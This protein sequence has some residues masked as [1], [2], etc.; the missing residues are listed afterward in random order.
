MKYY[1]LEIHE[2]FP[3]EIFI[4]DREEYYGIVDDEFY[5]LVYDE[6]YTDPSIIL[7]QGGSIEI[8]GEGYELSGEISLNDLTYTPTITTTCH[9][10]KESPNLVFDKFKNAFS[11]DERFNHIKYHKVSLVPD[12]NLYRLVVPSL[13][14]NQVF[15][16]TNMKIEG[17]NPISDSLYKG[18]GF[19]DYQI[20]VENSGFVYRNPIFKEENLV[21]L[22]AFKLWYDL[23]RIFVDEVFKNFCE[24]NGFDDIDFF[25]IEDYGYC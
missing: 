18:I 2:N 17:E 11:S 20:K 21:G 3:N 9:Y 19:T 15:D 13:E 12:L 4:Q 5:E 22:H 14:S 6:R 8:E 16:L 25:D 1:L 7:S 10:S 24:Q 23:G